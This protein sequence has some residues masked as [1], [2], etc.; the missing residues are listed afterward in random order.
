MSLLVDMLSWII[1]ILIALKIYLKFRI[2]RN[3][4]YRC[5]IGKTAIITGANTGI[6]YCTALD[7]ASR[8]ARV[9]LACR[10]EYKADNAQKKITKLTKNPNV[11]YKL[12][13][14][15][16]LAS[17]RAFAKDINETEERIDI[18]INNAGAGGLNNHVTNDG[19]QIT[20][21]VNHIS[22]FLLTHL[23]LDKIKKS[24]PSRI[25]NVSSISANFASTKV[26]DMNTFPQKLS[27]VIADQSMYAN[28]KLYNILFTTELSAKLEDT[29]VTANVLHPGA[30][31]TD[32]FRRI[33]GIYKIIFNLLVHLYF[34]TPE[35][36]A[37]T[38]IHVATCP[39]L[40]GVTG[41][42]FENCKEIELYT[43]ARNPELARDVWKISEEL[44][45]LSENEKIR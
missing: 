1:V 34:K 29:G 11:L 26:D 31:A 42:L 33:P 9:I 39:E 10:N 43:K 38:T 19:L 14:M 30:V 17:V 40:E 13:D 27:R 16:S 28:S 22:G 8:G 32:I 3:G 6:G 18:L 21:Q 45:K 44:A 5:L 35:E 20:L 15:T 24:A 7:L 2:K 37:Q 4:S 36:G 23:L 12:I 41:K 25:V